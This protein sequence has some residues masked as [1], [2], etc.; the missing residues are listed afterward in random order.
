MRARSVAFSMLVCN[1][2]RDGELIKMQHSCHHVDTI[3]I[4]TQVTQQP[5]CT[6]RQHMDA[7]IIQLFSKS[8]FHVSYRR[9]MPATLARQR[10]RLGDAPQSSEMATLLN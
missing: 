5:N 10:L 9:R 2:E 1:D 6:E 4:Q 8:Y 3:A 7:T